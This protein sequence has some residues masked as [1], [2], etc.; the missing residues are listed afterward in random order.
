MECN[1][2]PMIFPYADVTQ[3]HFSLQHLLSGTKQ[4]KNL[5]PKNGLQLNKIFK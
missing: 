2:F 1:D 5:T 3:I 4:K